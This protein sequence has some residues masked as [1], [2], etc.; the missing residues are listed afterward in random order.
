MYEH[1]GTYSEHDSLGDCLGLA[2][3]ALR[4]Q[5]LRIWDLAGDGGHRVTGGNGDVITDI[6]CVPQSG[7][8]WLTV[9][10]YSPDR[11][12]AERTRDDVRA[13]L[14]GAIRTA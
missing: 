4:Q 12:L 5:G 8:V 13:Y 2:A 7:A 1:W 9:S 11:A 10:T 6:V 3:E 14:T